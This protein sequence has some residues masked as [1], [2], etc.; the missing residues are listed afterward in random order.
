MANDTEKNCTNSSVQ[1]Y[2][3]HLKGE[4]EKALQVFA[5]AAAREG[6]FNAKLDKA[7]IWAGGLKVM[8]DQVTESYRLGGVYYDELSR[9]LE[10]G[11]KVSTNASRGMEAVRWLVYETHQHL[12]YTEDL[13]I[14]LKEFNDQID[15]KLP[16]KNAN[17]IVAILDE[18]KKAVDEAIEQV[19]VLVSTLMQ[20]VQE[21]TDLFKALISAKDEDK[22]GL[23]SVLEILKQILLTGQSPDL[24]GCAKDMEVNGEQYPLAG[25]HKFKENVEGLAATAQ[26]EMNKAKTARDA[27]TVK[28]LAAQSKKESLEAAYKA[29][30][31]ARICEVK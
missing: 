5:E 7:T 14:T 13:M 31:A 10:Q 26:E 6:Q 17:S 18:L 27:E 22:D 15:P 12:D 3:A 2:I 19:K 30:L 1:E 11:K 8:K 9:T 28:R 4:M 16:R 20:Q 25:F 24:C 29:A 21:E 23:V